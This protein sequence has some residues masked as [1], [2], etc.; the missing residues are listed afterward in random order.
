MPREVDIRDPIQFLVEGKDQDNFFGRYSHHIGIE[1]SQVFDFGGVHELKNYLESFV[2]ESNFVSVRSIGIIRDAER[3]TAADARRSV[4]GAVRAAGLLLNQPYGGAGAPAVRVLI[5]PD[6]DGPGML[7]TLLW[8]SVVDDPAIGCVEE[9]LDC[10]RREL[11][12]PVRR[13]DKARAHAFLATRRDPHVSV[14]V[15]AQRGYWNLDHPAFDGLKAFLREV[16]AAA[17]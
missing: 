3:G 10:V 15:A 14:G 9:F 7:E 12:E 13:L 16:V 11:G 6:D 1:R 8:R 4:E 17:G 5:L 2:L